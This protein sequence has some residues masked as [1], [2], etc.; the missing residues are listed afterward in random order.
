MLELSFAYLV[1]AALIG[2]LFLL[3]VQNQKQGWRK[4]RSGLGEIQAAAA[5][6]SFETKAD[7]ALQHLSDL[8][9]LQQS[10]AAERGA[11]HGAIEKEQPVRSR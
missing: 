9:R 1:A 8:V 6:A 2:G 3:A 10:L 5:L 7:P 11:V 4:Q